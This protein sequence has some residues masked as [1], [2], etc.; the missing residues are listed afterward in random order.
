[1]A[2]KK[3]A[4]AKSANTERPRRPPPPIPS[5]DSTP[6]DALVTERVHRMWNGNMPRSTFLRHEQ[7]DLTAQAITIGTRSKAYFCGEIKAV[8]LLRLSGAP[9]Q[10]IQTFVRLLVQARAQT[11]PPL[12]TI[13]KRKVRA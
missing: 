1:M 11:A 6:D 3:K 5:M 13:G 7:Q 12:P 10:R 9:P 8:R 2:A 4:P